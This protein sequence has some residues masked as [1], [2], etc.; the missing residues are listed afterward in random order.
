MTKNKIISTLES[1]GLTQKEAQIYLAGLSTEYHS[2]AELSRKT[3]IKRTTVYTVVEKLIAKGLMSQV[4]KGWK[5]YYTSNPPHSLQQLI[6]SKKRLMNDIL[7]DLK[8]L[9][10]SGNR[11]IT[12]KKHE[13][14]TQI[15]GAY[16]R[17][18][19]NTKPNEPYYV[20]ADQEYWWQLDPNFFEQFIRRRSTLNLDI[21]IVLK[22]SK[23]AREHAKKFIDLDQEIRIYQPAYTLR[24]NLVI[25]PN[26]LLIHD[27]INSTLLEIDNQSIIHTHMELFEITWNTLN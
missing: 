10:S 14:L 7:P 3:E 24:T 15:K 16:T 21:K 27:L 11:Q 8:N 18:L 17:I 12:L 4:P 6:E 19:E 22:D 1:I 23:I 13:N 2:I 9:H 25:T 5:T 26:K 20:F